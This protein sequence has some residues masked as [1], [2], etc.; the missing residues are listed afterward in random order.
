M[1]DLIKSK[2]NLQQAEE[3][4]ESLIED[5]IITAYRS[6]N[7]SRRSSNS[8]SVSS[9]IGATLAI[10]DY[11][12]WNGVK[13]IGAG[14]GRTGTASI[15]AALRILGF[16]NIYHFHCI[17][18]KPS[19]K[20]EFSKWI[21]CF[22][23]KKEYENYEKLIQYNLEKAQ[24]L[25]KELNNDDSMLNLN[26]QGQEASDY[27]NPSIENYGLSL[28]LQKC[29]NELKSILIELTY[30]YDVTLDHPACHFYKELSEIYPNAL[31][32]FSERDTA[33]SY[34]KSFKSSIGKI[35]SLLSSVQYQMV[36]Y[37]APM[38]PIVKKLTKH[39]FTIPGE[40]FHY[41]KLLMNNEQY[42]KTIK[43]S[44]FKRILSQQQ[45]SQKS[46]N[47]KSQMANKLH[48][49]HQLVY[50]KN[51]CYMEKFYIYH[52]NEFKKFAESEAGADKNILYF[53]VK[54][55]WQPLCNALNVEIPTAKFPH[56]N[57]SES[58]KMNIKMMY[59]IVLVIYL[60]ITFFMIACSLKIYPLSLI[61][62]A[63]LTIFK[64]KLMPALNVKIVNKLN[65]IGAPSAIKSSKS[66][67][68]GKIVI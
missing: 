20:A 42:Q 8:S 61:G 23:L 31:I 3:F 55:G 44:N 16:T 10:E 35:L 37:F 25:E 18:I 28:K 39:M 47:V 6:N 15:S 52:K 4:D 62:F 54:S 19:Q 57:S 49:I 32:L 21:K 34:T 51:L 26:F 59:R 50:N 17:R 24:K 5:G 66:S 60:L 46:K 38:H 22:E 7:S 33:S 53:N 40:S 2:L 14:L 48:P 11:N 64:C 1:F 29:K 58:M 36:G 45:D 67:T 65:G 12:S 43:N 41:K 68:D 30:G 63:F 27:V 13:I 9:G 56:V